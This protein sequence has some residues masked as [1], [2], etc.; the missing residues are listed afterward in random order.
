MDMDVLMPTTNKRHS[1]WPR[2]RC[3]GAALLSW[4]AV[5]ACLSMPTRP[6]REQPSFPHRVHVVDNQLACTF[7]HSTAL[8]GERPGMPP[9]ELCA[10]CHNQFDGNK[11]D[12]R[13]VGAFF[14]SQ[15][16]YRTVAS[17]G[18]T[19][20][21]MFSHQKHVSGANLD[22]TTCHQDIASQTSVPLEPIASKPRCMQC[23]EDRGM[24]NNCNEC[25]RNIDRTWQPH[26]HVPGSAWLRAHG[27]L[28]HAI[29]DN[30]DV[31]SNLQCSLCHQD[32]TG[33]NACHQQMPPR[34]H[35]STFRLR[36]HGLRASI[37]R[38]RCATCHQQDSC[39]QCHQTT[40]PRSH[41]GGFG[42]PQE[43]HCV[44]CHFP[45]AEEGCATCHRTAESHQLATPLPGD[46][47]AAMNC[48]LC[49]GQGQA[50]PHP[51][52]GHACTICHK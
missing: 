37:D 27:N 51:D 13:K 50:L 18:L 36:T 7:C 22:C 28:V 40:R 5:T 35:N 34:D 32:A 14:D 21:V 31:T 3:L 24:A 52:G 48:R 43:R 8:A 25:H 10:P 19:E 20:D 41:R 33:C 45:L 16:R 15:S 49:H 4:L 26:N 39:E 17:S 30:H 38:S 47:S 29:G 1:S 11:P 42:M 6:T 23:H 2:R 44:G 9:P 46:H 12:D